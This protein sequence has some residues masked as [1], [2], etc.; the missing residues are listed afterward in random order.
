MKCQRES[1]MTQGTDV[2]IEELTAQQDPR[3]QHQFRETLRSI[4]RMAQAEGRLNAM[5]EAR[6][7]LEVIS[8]RS[9]H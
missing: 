4:V 9:L 1:G 7:H 6:E 8:N 5:N 3:N 2:L